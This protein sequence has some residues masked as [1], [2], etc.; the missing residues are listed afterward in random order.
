MVRETIFKDVRTDVFIR[1]V[2]IR[3]LRGGCTFSAFLRG[4]PLGQRS[5]RLSRLTPLRPEGRSIRSPFHS[6][7][8]LPLPRSRFRPLFSQ[9]RARAGL[10]GRRFSLSVV[11]GIKRTAMPRASGRAGVTVLPSPNRAIKAFNDGTS[12][13]PGTPLKN[14]QVR[15]K[16]S[17]HRAISR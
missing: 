7:L 3:I 10:G 8:F 15:G 14:K 13:V 11:A 17:R 16:N 6:A 5:R 12:T 1:L 9:P 4:A 2:C